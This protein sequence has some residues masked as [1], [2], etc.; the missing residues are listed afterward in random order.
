MTGDPDRMDDPAY[1]PD[2]GLAVPAPRDGT[3]RDSEIAALVGRLTAADDLDSET[4]GR[5]LARLA[6]LLADSAR[7]AG[8]G[9]LRGG[10]WL[11]DLLLEVAPHV[12]VRDAETLRDHHHGLTGEALADNLVR[13][14]VNATTAVGAAGGALAAVEFVAPPLLLTAP[15]QLAAETLVIAAIEVKLIAELHAVYGV[16]V[17]GSGTTRATAFVTAWARQRGVNPLESG[18]LAN[19]LGSAAKTA[20]RKRLL[21]TFGRSM[22]TMGPFL[23]GAAA[24]AALNRS[25]TKRLAEAI[26]ADLRRH[27][28]VAPRDDVLPGAFP[29]ALPD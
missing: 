19:A 16:Q 11:A 21:R 22:S 18:T 4:R 15:A 20:L 14:A 17:P 6:R 29:Q 7:R 23:T 27:V 24:G 28:G 9:G 25:A 13:V 2:G 12:P 1:D 5:L 10:R 3:G 8:A 26:R